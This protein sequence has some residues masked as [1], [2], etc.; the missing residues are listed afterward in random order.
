MR[1]AM[2]GPRQVVQ[3][4]RDGSLF[5]ALYSWS[6]TDLHGSRSRVSMVIGWSLV[7]YIPK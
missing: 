2:T 1:L 7:R 4:G 3:E 5:L 6:D